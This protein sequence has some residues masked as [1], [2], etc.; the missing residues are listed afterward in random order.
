MQHFL[1]WIRKHVAKEAVCVQPHEFILKIAPGP[2][3]P[4]FPEEPFGLWLYLT[5]AGTL[6]NVIHRSAL[7]KS[8]KEL[9]HI[10]K[11]LVTKLQKS[12]NEHMI[13][14]LYLI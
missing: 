5:H 3:A 1:K 14:E 11:Q 4:Y 13:N 9:K 6:F 10:I 12:Q 8:I 2:I 7:Y